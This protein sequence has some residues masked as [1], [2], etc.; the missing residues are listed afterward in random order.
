MFQPNFVTF[1]NIDIIERNPMGGQF[2]GNQNNGFNHVVFSDG[3]GGIEKELKDWVGNK[4][5]RLYPAEILAA[6]EYLAARVG[7]A[8]NAPIRDCLFTSEG[9][10]TVIMPFIDGKTGEELGIEDYYPKTAQG[11]NLR[12]FDYLVANADR[13]PK[14]IIYVG[15]K[16][17]VGIDHALCNFR[18]R[19]PDTTLISHLWNNGLTLEALLI[20]RP[21]LTRLEPHFT[22][23]DMADKFQNLIDNL[24]KLIVAFT[25]LDS[26][27]TVVKSVSD[28]AKSADSFTPPQG[29][30]QAAKRALEWM[31]DGKAGVGFTS[32]GR[33]RASDLANG[34]AVSEVTLRR[35]KAYFDRH[36]VDKET[37]HWNEPSPGK[38]AWY[39][40]GGDAGYSWAKKMVAHFNSQDEVKKGDVAGHDFH[41]NQWVASTRSGEIQQLLHT[42]ADGGKPFSAVTLKRVSEKALGLS[43]KHA[44]W[45]AKLAQKPE[46]TPE[47]KTAIT[48]HLEASAK[49]GRAGRLTKAFAEQ[50]INGVFFNNPISQE[51]V[52]YT[53][54]TAHEAS[55]SADKAT[56]EMPQYKIKKGDVAGHPFHGNQYENGESGKSP[57]ANVTVTETPNGKI[58]TVGRGGLVVYRGVSG[59][60][61]VKATQNGEMGH[62]FFGRAIYTTTSFEGAQFYAKS[63]ANNPDKYGKF[64]EGGNGAVLRGVIKEGTTLLDPNDQPDTY[65]SEGEKY[66]GPNGGGTAR[67]ASDQGASGVVLTVRGDNEHPEDWYLITDPSKIQWESEPVVQKGDVSGHG[68]HGNQW[69]GGIGGVPNSNATWNGTQEGYAQAK[70]LLARKTLPRM[71]VPIPKGWSKSESGGKIYFTKGT[72]TAI[73]SKGAK[74]WTPGERLS[75]AAMN[76]IDK[77][78]EGKTLDFTHANDA[79]RATGAW[80]NPANPN[81]IQMG[82]WSTAAADTYW[83][84]GEIA[85][86]KDASDEVKNFFINNMAQG[87]PDGTQK[88]LSPDDLQKAWSVSDLI[89]SPEQSVESTVVH[90][91]GH[92]NFFAAGNHIDQIYSALDKTGQELGVTTP[93][94]NK[95]TDSSIKLYVGRNVP[96]GMSTPDGNILRA[97]LPSYLSSKGWGSTPLLPSAQSVINSLGSTKYGST[98]LQETVAEA[99]S[100]FQMPIIPDTPL[101]TN[102]AQALGWTKI[103][104]SAK[105]GF[106]T[107]SEGETPNTQPMG[108]MADGIL[109]PQWIEGD[110]WMDADGNWHEIDT[111]EPNDFLWLILE[112]ANLKNPE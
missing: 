102:I 92:S 101:V 56:A 57:S 72:N 97:D 47:T 18:P 27:A 85:G 13:R 48:K 64:A 110:K 82:K 96:Y 86:M 107:K 74:G 43:E 66:S 53:V 68:F 40:W 70:A 84:S 54:N 109:G 41:G 104:K 31:A 22:Q 90:E 6:Q 26:V 21:K 89:A 65:S 42:G 10:R 9:A 60:S 63:S 108:Y 77:Y 67:W 51:R 17:F 45:A 61:G 50:K 62:G 4:T 91:L 35:M 52:D 112:K 46:Q 15:E 39:A 24:E 87:F 105:L 5:H 2:K 33:K 98:T 36:Q 71:K 78:G 106:M 29:V 3:S 23:L 16:R 111:S 59:L 19:T 58:Y 80:V 79:D 28:V 88:E 20:I 55:I 93:D 7:E 75:T 32:V 95:I 44:N 73:F 14:N 30:Q 100:A 12:L 99:Y 38:V 11:E 81:T 76:A 69:T 1:T 8:I 34:H 25:A 103:T 37:P 94:W 83:R 49:W